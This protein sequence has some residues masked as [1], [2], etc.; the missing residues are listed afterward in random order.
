MIVIMC[1][2]VFNSVYVF[3]ICILY[4]ECIQIVLSD[5]FNKH[6]HLFVFKRMSV[7]TNYILLYNE[8]VCKSNNNQHIEEHYLCKFS[9]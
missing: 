1:L 5:F 9:D 3:D 2:G 8:K 4:T 6:F 7:S